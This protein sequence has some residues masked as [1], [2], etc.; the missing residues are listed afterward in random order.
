MSPARE[1]SLE[2]LIAGE[3]V[4]NLS[5]SKPIDITCLQA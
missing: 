2:A 4:S 1:K 5:M 3:A